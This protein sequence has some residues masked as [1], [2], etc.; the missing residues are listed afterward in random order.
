VAKFRFHKAA[1]ASFSRIFKFAFLSL[2]GI[3][4][5][6]LFTV[7]S[8]STANA[9]PTTV[10][11]TISGIPDE[12]WGMAWGEKLVSGTWVEISSSYTKDL[13]KGQTYSVNLGEVTGSTVRVWAQFGSNGGGYIAGTDS[14]TVNSTSITK[15]FS[16]SPFNYKLEV[17]NPLACSSGYV[18]ITTQ[19]PGFS[20]RFSTTAAINDTGV[21]N[22][23]LPSGVNF[24]ING[25]CNGDITFEANTLSTS[26]LQ[27]I[28]ITIAT[29]NIVGT[30]SGVTSGN[31]IYGQVQ[32]QTFNGVDT[33]W[34]N[35]GYNYSTNASGQFALN[36]PNG[37]YRLGAHP[38]WDTNGNSDFV[39]SNSDTFTVAGSQL[40]VNFSMSSDPNLI[41]TITPA[42]VSSSGWVTLEEKQVHP[43]KGTYFNY[44]DGVVVNAEGKARYFL[45]PGTYRFVVYPNQNG[46]GYVRTVSSEF[47]ITSGGAD[48]VGTL[49]LNQAN[50]KFVISPTANATEG[51]VVLQNSQGDEYEG[52]INESGVS[53]VYAPAGTYTATIS[54]GYPSATANTTTLTGLVVSGS[55]QTVNVTL[56]SGNVSGTVSPTATS[57]GGYIRVEKKV[58]GVK[59]YWQQISSRSAI[60][61]NGRY[62]LALPDGTYRIW[63][64]SNDGSFINTPGPE[65]TVAGS[66]VVQDLTLR[67]A[68]ITGT[69]SPTDKAANGS[70]YVTW[71][72]VETRQDYT[73]SALI[74]PDGSYKMALPNGRY[75][76]KA[77]ASGRWQ[78]YF[79]VQ[80]DSITVSSTPQVLNLTLL[81]AN[82]SGV[83]SPTEKSK[84]GWFEFEMLEAG[85]WV[86]TGTSYSVSN[87]GSYSV[88][89]PLGTYR[90]LINPNPEA[91]GVYRLTSDSF[92]VSAGSNTFNFTLPS[93][94]FSATVTPTSS[95]PGTS[96]TIEKL[97]SQGN[98]QYYGWANVNLNG[99]I[100]AYLPNGR[101]R[102]TFE[103]NGSE[104]VQTRSVSFDIP[105]S[106]D[107]PVPTTIALATPNISGTVTPMADAAYGQACLERKENNSFSYVTCKSLDANGKYGFKA[108]NGTYRVVV[109]P[110]SII[111]GNKGGYFPGAKLD[112]P[113]T[114]TTSDEFTVN[115]DSKVINI[116]LSTG[117]LSGTVSD[118]EKSA[119]GTI[120]VL[121]TDGAYPQWTN[122][123]TYISAQGKYALQLPVGQYR[124]QIFPREDATGVV[125]TETTDFTITGSTPIEVNVTLDTP[126][127]SGVI[128][129]IDKS[130]NGWVYAEQLT[131]K[132][133]WSGWSGA[134]GVATSS[135]IKSD[136]SYAMKLD[137]GISRVVAFPGYEAT[138]V[139]RTVSD[140]FTVTTGTT[141]TISF[142]LSEGNVRGTI[143]SITNSAGGWVRVERKNGNYWEW[144][145]YG[146]QVLQD[147]TYRLQ[148]DDGTYRILV[149]PGWRAANVVETPSGEF[150]V[151]GDQKTVNLTLLAP[152]LTG[153]I[154]NLAAAVDTSKLDSQEAR[155]YPAAHAYVLQK[156]GSNYIWINK[157]LTIF[158]DGSYST[159][160]PDGT[161]QIYVYQI[162]PLVTGLSRA[163]SN[164]IVISGSTNT[165]T[166]ALK[167]ANLRG[168]VT[169][170][171]MAGWG[172][173][174]AQK[175]NGAN[176]DWTSCETIR[177][178]GN[179]SLTVDPGV[180]RVVANPNWNSVGYSKAISDTA[181]VGVSGIATLN[182]A[183]ATANVKLVIN[184]LEAKPNYQGW[185]NVRDSAGNYVDTGKGW[186]SQL[187]KVD[188]TLDPG[189]YSLEIQPANNRSGVRTT[190]TITVTSGEV[191]QRTITL[192]AGN[193]Q[194]LAKNSSG[195][196]ISCAFITATATGQTTVKTI[197]KTDGTYTLNLTAGVA[198]TISAVDPNLGQVGST[199]LTPNNTSS[200]AVTVTTS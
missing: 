5:G 32:S 153:T 47:T 48:V 11:G 56:V 103:P 42:N 146:T 1:I 200:N 80:S 125:R 60:D 171:N 71:Q 27:T 31:K 141:N 132:C 78:N 157:Y 13:Y 20:E 33:K 53:F 114:T 7:L 67:V 134:P 36:L 161:Y 117:N 168:T 163:N 81:A 105:S 18:S 113:Y 149:S 26:N 86:H 95:S 72:D 59:V 21:A 166:F 175:Q 28:P 34:R 110:A 101:Y 190:E 143:S 50:L 45:E 115:N 106:V 83:I 112:S 137:N 49:A 2:I 23:S 87:S 38:N 155:S 96:A 130:A 121:K 41:Y 3:F 90:A 177:Q 39:N 108:P 8:A 30:I 129:P 44:L 194:G 63:A 136:G 92:T 61:E 180:Y 82:V 58:T 159:Y 94:N 74:Q 54:P 174:C 176:W 178:D 127:V 145:N 89:L 167:E 158:A 135:G 52:Y 184:D 119:G 75:K 68:N 65:F 66:P 120:Q 116:T 4:A 43:K 29:P 40:T 91:T 70:V 150:T 122:Y 187:G 197:S 10:T 140:S 93:S 107:F 186:I 17:S 19:D 85:N 46:D 55:S 193:V 128:T 126:N 9:A 170:T 133:G 22:L 172:W 138:G 98:F 162:N 76:L 181:T 104:F 195:T 131:C 6:F 164:D 64:E 152:N 189:I 124:L 73:Y 154:S 102:L 196:N 183:L 84:N 14:F 179:Y 77:S 139:T 185:V 160:L 156:I 51:S 182:V 169:P 88:Y 198:W 25:S 147:G 79:G 118:I 24:V 111:Y 173:V 12:S 191:L 97:Q 151:A 142:A 199:T 148:V 99:V 123:R 188:F 165:S 192:A 144:T 62:S 35:T 100:E 37:T 16:L 109:T 15:N 69:V 57:S